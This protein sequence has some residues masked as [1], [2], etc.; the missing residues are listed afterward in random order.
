MCK[1]I[2][3]QKM[4]EI[5]KN[6]DK[7]KRVT[8]V[9]PL[10]LMVLFGVL[11]LISGPAIADNGDHMDGG[12]MMDMGWW[13]SSYMWFMMIGY[14]AI[15]IIIGI[16]VYKDAKNRGMNGLLWFI[17]VIIPW[18]GILFLIIYLIIREDKTSRDAPQK[19]ATVILDE[20]YA[21]GEIT[22]EDYQKMK[23][24]ISN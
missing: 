4:V 1:L 8:W 23:R 22:R 17:L 5:K 20:R 6:V 21:T 24:D 7:N 14:W 12:G 15:F 19:S 13:G 3:V 18:I 16:L 10:L 9:K 11:L 2:E